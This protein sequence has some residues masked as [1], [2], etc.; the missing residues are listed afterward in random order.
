MRKIH[1]ATKAQIFFDIVLIIL[2]VVIMANALHKAPANDE[3]NYYAEAAT[4]TT[5]N[6][7]KGYVGF[8]DDRYRE[9]FVYGA[10]GWSLGDVALIVV[11]GKGTEYI[12]DDEAISASLLMYAKNQ[13]AQN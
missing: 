3:V 1:P 2:I 13:D 5:I 7:M 12:Y 9:L 8:T 4:V 10:D 6:E 11:D